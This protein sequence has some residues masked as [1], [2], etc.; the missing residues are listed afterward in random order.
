MLREAILN[1]ELIQ[2]TQ[3]L[4]KDKVAF[5]VPLRFSSLEHKIEWLTH[6]KT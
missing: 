6:D 3:L 1:V 5:R 2:A 4:L